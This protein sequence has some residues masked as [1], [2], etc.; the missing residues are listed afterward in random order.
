M[1]ALFW[2]FFG[3]L[4]LVYAGY[5]ALLW[6]AGLARPKAVA[7]SDITP[8]VTV[9]ISAYNEEACIEAT[10]ENKLAQDYPRD[11]LD[12]LVVSDGSTDETQAR[13]EKYKEHGV[14]L[15]VQP[16]RLGKTAALNR[17]ARE[18]RGEI[19]VFSDANSL[20]Q[21]DAVRKL[22]RNFHDARVGYV[23]GKMVYVDEAGSPVGSGCSAYMAYENLVRRL[24]TRVGSLVGVDG[25]I[26]AVRKSLYEPMG[27][28]LLPDLVLPLSVVDK[29][30]RVVYEE[31]A[32]LTEPTL[33]DT[34]DEM[35]M[36]VRVSLRSF[37]GLWHMRRLL[38]PRR[39]GFFAVQLFVHK[40]LRYF[41][42]FLQAG[43]FVTNYL[44]VGRGGFYGTAYI[45]QLGFY[46]AAAAGLLLSTLNVNLKVLNYPY[47][48]CLLNAA[49]LVAFFKFFRGEKQVV[50]LPRKG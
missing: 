29:G 5:P 32:V 18:A 40:W 39:A 22:V 26:D 34:K 17:A 13:V 9:V 31:N 27:H 12:V 19:I 38:N 23:T 20:Y 8:P 30:Y 24:E 44:L 33:T 43:L 36:R 4:V 25:G 2:I 21:K 15:L 46:L 49:S 28:D 35:D 6:L 50:W 14:R 47:Y 42:G 10:L 48:L 45:L 11:R 7:K 3:L 1:T 41:A 16:E 37:H